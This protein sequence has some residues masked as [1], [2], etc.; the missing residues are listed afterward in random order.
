ML[1]AKVGLF[2]KAR[3]SFTTFLILL[4]TVLLLSD[5]CNRQNLLEVRS[6]L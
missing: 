6:F 2:K 1:S 4:Y 5:S 3:T